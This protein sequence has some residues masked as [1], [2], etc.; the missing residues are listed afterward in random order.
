M[1]VLLVIGCLVVI[2]GCTLGRATFAEDQLETEW[3][4][5]KSEFGKIYDESEEWLRK[6]I[7]RDN[8]KIID[9]HNERWAA[10]D[11]SYEMGLNQFSDMLPKEIS[12]RLGTDAEI[13]LDED[14]EVDMESYDWSDY[15]DFKMVPSVNWTHMGAVTPVAFQG[16]FNSS[17][18]FAAAGVTESRQFLKSGKLPVLSKQNLVDCCRGNDNM[19]PR[20]LVCIKKLGGIDTE[21]S[22][23][24]RG[25]TGK[26]SFKRKYVGARIDKIFRV[27][28][29]NEQALAR[30]VTRGPIAAVISFTGL[31]HYKSGVYNDPH[32]G[33]KSNYAVLIVGYGHCK[34]FGDYWILKTSLG[35]HWGENGYL[36]LA[37]NKNNLCGIANNALY[38]EVV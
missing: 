37:R 24:Y 12:E 2:A 16:H 32:C 15:G 36:R 17:W 14:V 29:G 35:P 21:E 9:A 25:L 19:V 13:G 10:G 26:C 33:E 11:E 27:N 4:S 38:P 18:A 34:H 22:Y 1:R 31:M 23:P 30:S 8:K 7:F 28:P 20:A 5:Y 6:L 3:N